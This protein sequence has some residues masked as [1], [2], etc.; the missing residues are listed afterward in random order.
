MKYDNKIRA[1]PTA[2]LALHLVYLPMG[3]RLQF[4]AFK[5]GR[6]SNR[7]LLL[8]DKGILKLCKA[9]RG[10]MVYYQIQ[11]ISPCPIFIF[12]PGPRRRYN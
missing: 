12:H 6:Q 7:A 10:K 8:A 3:L 4:M 5:R 1:I 11:A 2:S 9:D